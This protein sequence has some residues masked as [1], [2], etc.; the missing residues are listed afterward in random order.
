LAL[1]ASLFL[2]GAAARATAA[3][4]PTIEELLSA[5]YVGLEGDS[6]ITLADGQWEGAPFVE[7]SAVRPQVNL[8]RRYRLTGD[9][10]NDGDDEAVVFLSQGLGGS[11]EFM[12]IAVVDRV[13]DAVKN[14]ATAALGDQ[15]Q[16]REASI[17]KGRLL[18]D[19]VQ[20]GAPDARCCPGDWLTRTWTLGPKGLAE[21]PSRAK[22]KRLGPDALGGATWILRSWDLEEP[23]QDSVEV[24]LTLDGK[25]LT[26][27]AGCNRYVAPW[28]AGDLPGEI[29]L[30][31][32]QSTLA[33]CPEP[34]QSVEKRYL[35]LI[36]R[37]RKF[38]FVAT[39][40]F[41]TWEKGGAYG[42]M[43]FTRRA[44]ND[45]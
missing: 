37:A 26:G 21:V 16:V 33:A 5:T 18:L 2:L 10:D 9:L 3:P 7:G 39:D 22:V 31:P 13:G 19:V 1:L 6:A 30:G 34:G 42:T 17:V 41:V 27:D 38:A 4:A 28:K 25:V 32:I 8:I 23:L 43:I 36:D 14:V 20:V 11:G 35:D 45:R 40:L 29:R 44:A 12:Y 15:V 24:T